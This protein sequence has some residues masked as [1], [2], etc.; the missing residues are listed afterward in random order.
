MSDLPKQ[1]LDPADLVRGTWQLYRRHFV[2][3]LIFAV[4]LA[5]P[6]VVMSVVS[7]MSWTPLQNSMTGMMAWESGELSSAEVQRFLSDFIRQ[8]VAI[9]T[10]MCGLGFIVGVFQLLLYGTGIQMAGA[11]YKGQKVGFDKA[12]AVAMVERGVTFVGGHFLV[13]VLLLALVVASSVLIICCIGLLGYLLALYIGLAWLPMLGPVL[14]L[15]RGSFGRLMSRAWYF[16]RKRVFLILI[17]AILILVLNAVISWPFNALGMAVAPVRMEEVMEAVEAGRTFD[18]SWVSWPA[19][20]LSTAGSV[21]AQMIVTP[22]SIIFYT[23]L[24]YDT[25]L[26]LEPENFDAV[27]QEQDPPE[28]FFSLVKPIG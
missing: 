23:L 4:L 22:F 25:R 16:G 2:Q 24:Y 13:G 14:I 11:A 9:S 26:R 27:Y 1:P 3:W 12:V 5:L 20:I 8:I 17:A 28:P 19:L 10:V 7:F 6:T 15:E 21:I 18:F